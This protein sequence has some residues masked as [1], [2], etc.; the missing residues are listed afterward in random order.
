MWWLSWWTTTNRCR[1]L[2]LR[3]R[4]RFYS[5]YRCRTRPWVALTVL[6]GDYLGELHIIPRLNAWQVKRYLDT[7]LSAGEANGENGLSYGSSY[8]RGGGG[9]GAGGSVQLHASRLEGGGSVQ[10]NGGNGG[11]GYEKTDY[12]QGGGGGGGRIA[13]RCTTIAG[14]IVSSLTAEGGNSGRHGSAKAAGAGTV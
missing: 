2:T 8:E 1:R 10:A 13:M 5:V 4:P 7:Q 9:G 11:L 6:C 14:T 3:R 12:E